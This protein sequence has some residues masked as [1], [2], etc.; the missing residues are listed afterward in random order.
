M[1][2]VILIKHKP[3]CS[4]HMVAKLNEDWDAYYCGLCNRWLEEG[5]GRTKKDYFAS[6]DD[7][8]IFDCA[9]RPEKPCL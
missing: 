7:G 1:Q 8:C 5:C 2:N 6:T 3:H 4:I 9:N